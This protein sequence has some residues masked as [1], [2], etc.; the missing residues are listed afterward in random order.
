MARRSATGSLLALALI[1]T[2]L[3]PGL[4]SAQAASNVT[5]VGALDTPG[6]AGAVAVAAAPPASYAYVADGQSGLRIVDLT[7]RANPREVGALPSP[8]S[9]PAT[10]AHPD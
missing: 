6:S 2:W 10:G 7:D 4:A 9:C 8:N 1:A 5:R 3:V